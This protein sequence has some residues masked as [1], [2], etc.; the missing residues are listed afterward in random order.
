MSYVVTNWN[1]IVICKKEQ[2]YL[3]DNFE[4]EKRNVLGRSYS[5]SPEEQ[6]SNVDL[7][8]ML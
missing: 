8:N 1:L 4:K 7:L 2:D 6:E 3:G 5:K